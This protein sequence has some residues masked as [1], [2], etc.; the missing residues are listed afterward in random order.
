MMIL[1]RWGFSSKN[2]RTQAL[3]WPIDSTILGSAWN[4]EVRPDGYRRNSMVRKGI[5]TGLVLAGVLA[6]ASAAA[7]WP[8]SRG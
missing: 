1:S 8:F 3:P 5:I 6:G 4:I 2:L 7:A